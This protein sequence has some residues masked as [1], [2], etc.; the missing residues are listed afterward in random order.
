GFA[1]VLAVHITGASQSRQHARTRR[2]LPC[3]IPLVSVEVLRY[4]IKR[5][6]C[7]NAGIV[8][9]KMELI[10][11]QTQQGIS[12]EVS[13]STKGGEELERKVKTN[14]KKKEALLTLMA[15]TGSIHLLSEILSCSLVLK[16]VVMDLMTRCTTLPSHSKSDILCFKTHGDSHMSID[17]LTLS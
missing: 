10:L 16:T 8:P 5:S 17:F 14:A 3:D 6:K 12:H 7:E 4:D 11:E 1:A 13:V 9:T 15:E 2:D